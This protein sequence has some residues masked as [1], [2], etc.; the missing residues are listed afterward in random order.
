M[1]N[2]I[3][4]LSMAFIA[5]SCSTTKNTS[6][7]YVSGQKTICS[8]G[9]GKKECLR[10]YEGENLNNPT[11][12]NFYAPIEG[13]EFEEGVLQKILVKKVELKKEDVPADASSIKYS[14]VEVLE[15]QK[16]YQIE[17]TNS[18][19]L[20][21]I[22]NGPLNRMVS[23]PTLTIDAFTNKILGSDGC[24]NYHSE[25]TK[26]NPNN[27]EFGV[28][29]ST[30]KMC[31]NKNISKEY[32]EAISKVK[33]YKIEN[34]K[35][36]LM[37]Q[38]KEELLVFIKKITPKNDLRLNDIW[39]VVKL[40]GNPLNKMVEVPRLEINLKEMKIMGNNGCNEYTGEI[41]DLNDNKIS[42]S[43]IITT[44]KM[45]LKMEVSNQ[46]D[47]ALLKTKSYK[48]E[49]TLLTFY[50]EN[51]NELITFLKAD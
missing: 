9:A 38:N 31:A 20:V 36:I 27:I 2:T 21:K 35:L 29:A 43:K 45:C 7:Y 17:I 33:F 13:F 18:W 49:G 1:K 32:Y 40:G 5:Q 10:T 24:N 23:V 30:K 16:D 44:Q 12:V 47:E 8:S 15:K 11:W 6:T 4:I 3:I 14:L 41:A 37:N 28:A 50:D 19:T 26:L 48:L 51:N 46:F 25:I 42:F 34:D 22:N 39:G